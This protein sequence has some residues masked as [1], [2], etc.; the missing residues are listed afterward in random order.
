MSNDDLELTLDDVAHQVALLSRTMTE[1]MFWM[2]EAEKSGAVPAGLSERAGDLAY[3][4][5]LERQIDS[6]RKTLDQS[7]APPNRPDILREKL[8]ESLVLLEGKAGKIRQRL[9]DA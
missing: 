8:E 2:A 3:L 4:H 6:I 9:D 1:I 7:A 5:R